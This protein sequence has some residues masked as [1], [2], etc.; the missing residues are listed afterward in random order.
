M[1]LNKLYHFSSSQINETIEQ[2]HAANGVNS[3]TGTYPPSPL[4]LVIVINYIRM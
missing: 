3:T 4:F 1:I 2:P